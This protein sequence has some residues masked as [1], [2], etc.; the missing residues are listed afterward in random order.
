[1]VVVT[2]FFGAIGGVVMALLFIKGAQKE[3][4][5]KFIQR[6]ESLYTW[7]RAN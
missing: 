2:G 4:G 1:M 6:L 3:G 7:P 5:Y